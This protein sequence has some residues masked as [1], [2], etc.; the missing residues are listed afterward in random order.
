ME[1]RPIFSLETFSNVLSSL[2]IASIDFNDWK[3]SLSLNCN[4][5]KNTKNRLTHRKYKEEF[6]ISNQTKPNQTKLSQPKKKSHHKTKY[7]LYKSPPTFSISIC[8]KQIQTNKLLFIFYPSLSLSNTLTLTRGVH[9]GC[10]LLYM[11]MYL[12]ILYRMFAE[13]IVFMS[14][15]W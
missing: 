1:Q 9:F 4:E 15:V 7:F 10:L 8:H 6:F 2:V 11:S 5:T 3:P 12:I 14:A 13:E